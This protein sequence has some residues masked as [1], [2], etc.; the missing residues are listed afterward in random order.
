MNRAI[1]AVYLPMT[2]L[3]GAFILLGIFISGAYR[4]QTAVDER[5]NM[6]ELYVTNRVDAVSTASFDFDTGLQAWRNGSASLF[7]RI[8]RS[9]SFIIAS[10]QDDG[11]K[12]LDLEKGKSI[13]SPADVQDTRY[14]PIL[15]ALG[16]ESGRW[17]GVFVTGQAVVGA[18]RPVPSK[19][20][21]IFA[22]VYRSE[23][24]A[25][26]IRDAI[27]AAMASM[28][29]LAGIMGIAV[30]LGER[31]RK[32]S[33]KNTR[34]HE[35][36]FNTSLTGIII[37]DRQGALVAINNAA[38]DM[39]GLDATAVSELRDKPLDAWGLLAP[40]GLPLPLERYPFM[41]LL[42]T[43]QTQCELVVGRQLPTEPRP[44]W[45]K[46][47]ATPSQDEQGSIEYVVCSFSEITGERESMEGIAIAGKISESIIEGL[48]I[49][50]VDGNILSVNKAFTEITGWE[51]TEVLGKNPRILKSERHPD[52]FYRAMWKSLKE[53]GSWVGEIWNR[54]KNGTVYPEWLSITAVRDNDGKPSHYVAVFRD[55]TDIKTRDDA[56][57]KLSNHDPLTDLP[58]RALCTDR[59]QT[60]IKQAERDHEMIAVM[61]IDLDHF[62]FINTTYG[63]HLGDNIL[64]IVADR[65]V[66]SLRK[67]DT[68]ARVAADD[69]LV[70]IPRLSREEFAISGAET[71]MKAIRQP[72]LLE[73][74]EVYLDASIGISFYPND[75]DSADSI[76]GAANVALNRAKE[77]GSG[78]FHIFTQALNTRISKR[79]SMDSRLRKAVEK[80]AFTVYYQPRVNATTLKVESMEALVRWV[81]EDSA[82][83][84]PG[85]F[86]SLAEENGLIVPI[87]EW[88][89][90]KALSD[91]HRWQ[92]LDPFLKV[93]VNLSARQFRLPD[94]ESRIVSAIDSSG[95][96]ADSLELEITESLAMADVSHSTSI[97]TSLNKRG[98]SFSLDDFG[99]GYSSLYYLHHLPI[100]WLKIDQTFVREIRS[101]AESQ[102]NAI[103]TTIIEMARNLGL[104]TIAEGC[105]TTEQ[106]EFLS[107]HGCEQIQGYLFSRPVPAKDFERLIGTNLGART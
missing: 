51:S 29:G 33:A 50:D 98:V 23:I 9:G 43:R 38:M 74:R 32:R 12:I 72:I 85:D 87:G 16:G 34:M 14:E 58:N 89:L 95:V 47:D 48:S 91:L 25:P 2:I 20:A 106:H 104:R 59:L 105:E 6:L 36:I 84:Q 39:F 99:T 92:Q 31:F 35:A 49:T 66:S 45:F 93:S 7:S 28:A 13:P 97:L 19:K 26:I 57:S 73:G 46:V 101:P 67:G 3:A 94:L 71:I 54:R 96:P 24:T 17:A 4:Y 76:I 83:I 30:R 69:F 90:N 82:I 68:V 102:G 10:V 22:Y 62:K 27:W 8:N 41:R 56:I 65:L 40:D 21:A 60:A 52:G 81:D 86:I 79:L 80:E 11:M 64:Q 107:R 53:E 100:Q 63:Y 77:T 88:V 78:T 37:H 18:F 1:R 44:R 61:Y 42:E 5:L 55:L 103:V 70:I 15:R 75:G